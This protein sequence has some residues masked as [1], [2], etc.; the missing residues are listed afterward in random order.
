MPFSTGSRLDDEVP[1]GAEVAVEKGE[2]TEE[3]DG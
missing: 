2:L 1:K 3:P